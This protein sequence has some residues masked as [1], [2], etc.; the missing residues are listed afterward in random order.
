MGR[1]VCLAIVAVLATA[2]VAVSEPY[3]IQWDGSD[4]PENMDPAWIR[5]WGN[6]QGPHQ[7]GAYRTLEDGVLTY[8]SLYDPGVYDFYYMDL[9]GQMSLG[10]SEEFV[11]E[12]RLL[13]DEVTGPWYYDPCVG[14]QSDDSWG[15]GLVFNT[16]S[17]FSE[18]ENMVIGTFAPGEFHSFQLRSSDMRTYHLTIDSGPG[19]DGLFDHGVST[20]WVSWGDECR[21][22]RACTTGTTCASA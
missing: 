13:V 12:W 22:R 10:P 15:V 19:F 18:G 2:G 20:S 17:V 4:W 16:S 21:G 8:D 7:G 6:W 5:S 9:P 3:W 11:I 14:I 1:L